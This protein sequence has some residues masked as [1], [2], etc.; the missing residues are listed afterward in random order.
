MEL[1]RRVAEFNTPVEDLK[2]IYILFIRS[3]LEQSATV[4]HSS[5]TQEN[6]NDLERIQK[7]ATKIILKQSDMSYKKRLSKLGLETLS[8]RREYLCLTFAQKCVK[9]KRTE[10]MFPLNKKQHEMNTRNKEKYKVN[11]ANA[12]RIKNSPI[13]SMQKLLNK[14]EKG[15]SSRKQKEKRKIF[16]PDPSI[17]D[18]RVNFC[19]YKVVLPLYTFV[20]AI[21]LNKLSLSP[22][23]RN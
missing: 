7:S 9:N 16:S 19:V 15:R 8:S 5:L 1:L 12:N 13:I 14:K 22:K 4:W 17:T 18:E 10:H 20:Y 6:S 2:N 11:F 23:K 21:S 3:I